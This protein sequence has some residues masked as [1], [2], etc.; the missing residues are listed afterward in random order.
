MLQP[1]KVKI[2]PKEVS[3]TLLKNVENKRV[4][5]VLEKRFGLKS[6]RR[7]TLEA[8]GKEH[9][10]T[11]ERV[12]QIEADGLKALAKPAVYGLAESA[13]KALEDHL[14]E[15]GGVAAERPLLA[16]IAPDS[17][18]PH[19]EFL[20]TVGKSFQKKPE[21]K[22]IYASWYTK[23][24]ACGAVERILDNVARELEAGKTPIKRDELLRLIAR[25]AADE[26][27]SQ[28]RDHVV[29]NILGMARSIG[30]N[31][32]GEYGLVSWPTIQPKGVRDK[33]YLVL[34]KTG[35]PM[36]FRK[37]AE[38]I[39]AMRGV[40]RP[41]HPQ[42]VHNELIKTGNRFVLVGRGLY[43]LREW[44]YTPGTVAEVVKHVLTEA[45]VPLSREEIVKRVLDRR[46]VK[47]NT[48]LLNLQNKNLFQRHSD[49]KYF[50]V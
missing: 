27:K 13:F 3:Q 15:H 35:K 34:Q 23:D 29:S 18:H 48:I 43:A 11:R 36:H 32:Y 14:N 39:N 25:H 12:R 17:H 4:R 5:E 26:L 37:V 40:K 42:T 45:A 50:V 10:I 21:T 9:G 6:G 41:A 46:F 28:P 16:S 2:N 24:E 49:G 47:E 1:I 38:A 33:A 22:A 8:I 19:I 44:G 31:P 30:E 7:L 20:L